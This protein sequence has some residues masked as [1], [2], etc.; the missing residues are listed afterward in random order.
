MGIQSIVLKHQ[1][2]SPVLCGKLGHVLVTEEDLAA[3]RCLEPADHV[4]GRALPAARGAQKTDELPIRD[5]QGEVRY[6]GHLAPGFF[7]SVGEFLGQILKGHV[8]G[9]PSFFRYGAI[10][11]LEMDECKEKVPSAGKRQ[12]ELFKIGTTGR[13]DQA[14]S[15]AMRPSTMP[16]REKSWPP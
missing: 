8:H 6:G 1:P 4:K 10:I 5:L 16:H 3:G 11:C 7:V 9:I 2:N 14:M 15:L 12:R 13:I